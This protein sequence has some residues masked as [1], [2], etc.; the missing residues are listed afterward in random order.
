MND[1]AADT[2]ARIDALIAR[3]EPLIAKDLR[4]ARSYL[5]GLF[6]RGYELVYD[7]YNALAIGF[8]P[9]ER[10]SEA[11]VSVAAYPRWVTLF[12][13]HGKNL[14][15]PR[16]LLQGSGARVRSIRL[17]PLSLLDS[18]PVK[19]LLTQALRPYRQALRT[20][21]IRSTILKSVSASQRPRRPVPKRKGRP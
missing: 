2:E 21:P 13:L 12:F 18:K 14:Q 5:A 17:Q 8:G 19:N 1:T 7:N 10:S 15:D 6:P 3:Y 20:A 4:T 11:I 9:S 16:W